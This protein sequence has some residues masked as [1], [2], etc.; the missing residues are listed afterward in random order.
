MFTADLWCGPAYLKHMLKQRAYIG[1]MVISASDVERNKTW[2]WAA[3]E[4]F[5]QVDTAEEKK[6]WNAN[7]SQR[8]QPDIIFT[9]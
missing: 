3:R 6:N 7:H 1:C 5:G 2:R 9:F 8:A 4:L